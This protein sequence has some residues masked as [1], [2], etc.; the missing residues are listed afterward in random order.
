MA[1]QLENQITDY[2]YT[3]YLQKILKDLFKQD[4]ILLARYLAKRFLAT[5]KH[6]LGSEFDKTIKEDLLD[7]LG[8]CQDI[9]IQFL[10]AANSLPY[11]S[12]VEA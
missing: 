2:V 10:L 4:S 6:E 9:L 8:I 1:N 12:T 5:S 7:Y 3:E 11:L